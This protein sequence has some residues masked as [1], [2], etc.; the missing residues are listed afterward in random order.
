VSESQTTRERLKLTVAYDGRRFR[1]WQ[2]QASGDA[3]Q[4]FLEAA[5]KKLVG[6]RVVVQGAGRTDAGVHALAQ[7]AHADVPGGKYP[8]RTWMLAI[9]DSLPPEARVIRVQR[10]RPEFHARFDAA[11]KIYAYRLWTGPCLHP[12][13]IGRAWHVPIPLDF[14]LLR[15]G[16]D[17]LCG[18]HDF[19]R[20][21]VNRGQVE[22]DTVRTIHR[23]RISRR[24]PLVTLRFE[25]NGFLYKM[26]RVLTGSLVRVAQGRA[27]LE[28]L[29]S[30]LNSKSAAKSHFAAPAEGLYLERVLY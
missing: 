21:A 10:A 6:H 23:I 28:W 25:G 20:F 3:V 13:E 16:A 8:L 29:L 5:F 11:G 14:T 1:G 2:S 22:K 24:G 26:V 27:P 17:A 9:N 4:D 12:L 19:A 30:T 15:A 7:I 18:T